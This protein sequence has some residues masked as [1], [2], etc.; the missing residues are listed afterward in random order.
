MTIKDDLNQT[1]TFTLLG[2]QAEKF[3]GYTCL[4]LLSKRE[5]KNKEDFPE[6]ITN[7]VCKTY[8]FELKINWN[9]EMIV[10]NIHPDPDTHESMEVHG[11]SSALREEPVSSTPEKSSEKKKNSTANN[12][13]IDYL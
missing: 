11:E 2:R 9:H 5:Y 12:K 13:T 1:I 4:E 3:F 10:R 7:K 8:L 6:E